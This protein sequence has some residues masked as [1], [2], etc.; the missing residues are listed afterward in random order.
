M[1]A[2]GCPLWFEAG[3]QGMPVSETVGRIPREH[4]VKAKLLPANAV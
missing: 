4:F 2:A 3:G 1:A